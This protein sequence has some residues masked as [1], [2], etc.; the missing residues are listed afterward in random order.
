MSK[1]Y[2]KSLLVALS[3]GTAQVASAQ[4]YLGVGLGATFYND[5]EL[6]GIEEES[7]YYEFKAGVLVEKA[8]GLEISYINLGD[9]QDLHTRTDLNFSGF[10]VAGKGAIP[11]GSQMNLFAKIGMFFWEQDEKYRGQSHMVQEGEDLFYGGGVSFYVVD[12]L[13]VDLEYRRF[14]IVDWQGVD[15]DVDVFTA[16]FSFF[17]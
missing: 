8:V 5:A 9:F 6:Y 2:W 1:L 17:F 11:V 15:L 13:S 12:Q 10:A 4:P 14:E 7:T 3:L 16:G